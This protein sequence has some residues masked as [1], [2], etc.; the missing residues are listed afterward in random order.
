MQHRDFCNAFVGPQRN[1][2]P[3]LPENA[4]KVFVQEMLSVVAL[5]LQ[6]QGLDCQKG[7]VQI[8]CWGPYTTSSG[9]ILQGCLPPLAANR[10][11]SL[12]AGG[13]QVSL[14]RIFPSLLVSVRLE[15]RQ[16]GIRLLVRLARQFLKKALLQPA[17]PLPTT[18]S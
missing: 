8:F 13:N 1:P 15:S 18:L 3:G 6:H 14:L 11:F 16:G 4:D 12:A 7:K 2:S 17:S 5:L 9:R 10:R